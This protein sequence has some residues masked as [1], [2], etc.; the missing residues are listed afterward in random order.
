MSRQDTDPESSPR[1][2]CAR[3]IILTLVSVFALA[4]IPFALYYGVLGD[5]I[6]L[7]PWQLWGLI[8]GIPLIVF[9]Y[10]AVWTKTERWLKR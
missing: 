6:F 10:L 2:L 5:E 8:L 9:L 7:A 1:K 4:A 3:D